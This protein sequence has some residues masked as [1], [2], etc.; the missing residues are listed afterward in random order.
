M[1]V[2]LLGDIVGRPGRRIVAQYLPELKKE[3]KPDLIV[4]NG[5]NAAGGFG[6]TKK[7]AEELFGLGIHV[8]TSG[9]HIWDQKEMYNYI[10]EEPRLLRP[11]N[12]PPGT[13]GSSV[14]VHETAAAFIA[15]VN[16]IGRV[17]LLDVDCPFRGADR[18]LDELPARVTHVIIDFHGEATSEKIALARYLDGRISALVGT[19]TH[20]LTADE[21]ILPKGT[22]YITDLGMCGPK[23]G[24]LGVEADVVINKF[25]TQLPARFTVAKG[26]AQLNGV[27]IELNS[28]GTA[29]HITKLNLN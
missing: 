22:A 16:L 27:V 28:E 18:I 20:V 15:V 5:E 6:L 1:N 2:L 17:F 7:V 4:A 8:L 9:N 23:D 24:V 21:Q 10:S 25:L 14:Y 26:P 12:Y 19:H 13:P 3:H 11:A 29:R